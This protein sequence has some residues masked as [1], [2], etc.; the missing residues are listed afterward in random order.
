MK[1]R[2]MERIFIVDSI[3]FIA[4]EE[5]QEQSEA[6]EPMQM[7]VAF[8]AFYRPDLVDLQHEA[9]KTDAPA[10]EGKNDPTPYNNGTEVGDLE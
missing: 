7:T 10:P 8:S 5:I 4:P 1:S 6:D 9:P 2:R 3:N